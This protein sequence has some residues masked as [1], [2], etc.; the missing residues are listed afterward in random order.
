MS[1]YQAADGTSNQAIQEPKAIEV[2]R[3]PTKKVVRQRKDSELEPG[4]LSVS[5]EEEEEEVVVLT[6]EAE[7][8]DSCET[9]SQA[10]QD[11][12]KLD[13]VGDAGDGEELNLHST[14]N[15][16][17]DSL[18][19][20]S[21]CTTGRDN[22]NQ[23]GSVK[24]PSQDASTKTDSP[25]GKD[26]RPTESSLE[27]ADVQQSS[28]ETAD[29][30]QSSLETADAQQSSAETAD[31]QQS[32]VETA[33]KSHSAPH[34][35]VLPSSVIQD[36]VAKDMSAAPSVEG[37]ETDVLAEDTCELPPTLTGTITINM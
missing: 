4:E 29:P 10:K 18:G 2:V 17:I 33:N 24:P 9:G 1:P 19:D 23:S 34:G 16:N 20:D 6:K 27:T 21:V 8:A 11:E 35:E 28:S 13:S 12:Q 36:D 15:K 5:E 25:S 3:K 37:D 7:T 30:Q 31:A 22:P 26:I 14:E 32:S